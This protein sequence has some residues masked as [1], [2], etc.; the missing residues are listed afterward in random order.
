[1]TRGGKAGRFGP[2]HSAKPDEGGYE[3]AEFTTIFPVI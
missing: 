2:V 1:M 3:P